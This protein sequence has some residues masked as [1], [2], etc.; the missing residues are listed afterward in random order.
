MS[1]LKN[2]D[3][4]RDPLWLLHN[5]QKKYK[6]IYVPTDSDWYVSHV[7]GGFTGQPMRAY[8]NTSIVANSRGMAYVAANGLNSGNINYAMIDWT[9]RL[10]LSFN[11][12][13]LSSDTEV[14]ARVQLKEI[15]TE[16]ILAERGIGIDITNYVMNGEAFGTVR[17]T[18]AT[19]ATL[20]DTFPVQVKIV[21]TS[22]EVQFYINE[23]L[24][25]TLA[26]TALPN[27]QGTVSAFLVVSI[28]NGATGGV[29]AILIIS[30]IQIVQGW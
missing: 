2:V 3:V 18:T 20:T 22:S 27:V 9:K 12:S 29:N 7:G 30:D 17:G 25:A 28:I 10:E 16:G 1:D 13:R 6:H 15:G 21:V 5:F 11:I 14:V 8:V 24:T 4:F 19:L 23:V 26:G